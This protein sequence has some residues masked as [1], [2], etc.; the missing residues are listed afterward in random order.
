MRNGSWR[1]NWVIDGWS[2]GEYEN[3]GVRIGV[4]VLNK[5]SNL[6]NQGSKDE[7]NE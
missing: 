5:H 7:E 2:G 6:L 1:R 4:S 3:F